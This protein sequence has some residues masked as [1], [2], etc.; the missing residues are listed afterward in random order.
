MIQ[1]TRNVHRLYTTWLKLRKEIRGHPY[2]GRT[3]LVGKWHYHYKNENG[4]EIGLVRLNNTLSFDGE[5]DYCYEACGA[6]ELEQFPTLAKA[7][8]AIYKKLGE[9]KLS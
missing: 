5:K 1:R 8:E 3:C 9:P 7:E 4:Q 2:F 6:L